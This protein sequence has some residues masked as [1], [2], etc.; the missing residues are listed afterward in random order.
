MLNYKDIADRIKSPHLIKEDE[1]E[2]LKEL[3]SRFPYSSLFAQLYL[4][5]LALH[6]TLQFDV[7]LEKFAFRIPDRIQLFYLVNQA[8]NVD[9]PSAESIE[10][11]NGLIEEIPTEDVKESSLDDFSTKVTLPSDITMVPTEVKQTIEKNNNKDDYEDTA[12]I[13]DTAEIIPNLESETIEENRKT[14]EERSENPEK[15]KLKLDELDKA[16]L[17]H[18]VSSS[19]LL[20]VDDEFEPIS[21]GRLRE[22]D[23]EISDEQQQE[24]VEESITFHFDLNAKEEKEGG[25]IE[26]KEKGGVFY[27]F[28]DWMAHND[29]AHNM[30]NEHQKKLEENQQ[31]SSEINQNTP[32]SQKNIEKNKENISIK[33]RENIFY[34]PVQK[35]KESLDESRLPVSETLAK[36]YA[37]Q[38][39]Y[40]KAINAY[41]KLI[42]KFPKKKTYFA[43]QIEI[44]KKKL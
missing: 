35:A 2:G 34:S 4:K 8:Q 25:A 13:S 30:P 24:V 14:D 31:S 9:V 18:A 29:K 1:V 32:S 27:S 21:F 28:T 12:E 23:N 20:E 16:I 42:L 41:E 17:A 6:N 19:I 40:P 26:E 37:L 36:I 5:A 44:L 38:G 22:I 7:E 3:V 11:K 39:N 43:L 33:R 10:T 15:H